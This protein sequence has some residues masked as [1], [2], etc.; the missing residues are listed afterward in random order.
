MKKSRYTRPSAS[1]FPMLP[2]EPF[3]GSGNA[4]TGSLVD[5]DDIPGGGGGAGSVDVEDFG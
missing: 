4:G 5:F 2:D 3:T 1:E